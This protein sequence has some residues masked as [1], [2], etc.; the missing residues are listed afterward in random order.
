MDGREF[1]VRC[2]KSL[3]VRLDGRLHQIEHLLR[4][5][6]GRLKR[7]L[8]YNVRQGAPHADVGS[9]AALQQAL[10]DAR[11]FQKKTAAVMTYLDGIGSWASVSRKR[12]SKIQRLSSS[13]TSRDR[14]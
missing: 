8:T 13:A 4:L 1:A 5:R 14:V 10:R 9:E 3:Q 2:L 6:R 11:R 7:I 12:P